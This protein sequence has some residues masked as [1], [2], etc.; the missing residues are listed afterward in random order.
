MRVLRWIGWALGAVVALVMVAAALAYGASERLLRQASEARAAAVD[1]PTDANSIAE[2][3][4]LA[5]V[6]GCT[7]CHGPLAEGNL[8][9]DE[10]VIATIVAP[11]SRNR[12]GSTASPTSLRRSA[13]AS[14][15]APSGR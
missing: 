6:H 13:T 8:L 9:V 1:I 11:N 10:P 5:M 7:G 14:A 3:N 2:G 4:R 15:R 12:C